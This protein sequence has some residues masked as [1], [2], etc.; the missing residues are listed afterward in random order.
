MRGPWMT[1][2]R[3]RWRGIVTALMAAF[4]LVGLAR[5]GQ[6]AVPKDPTDALPPSIQERVAE[7]RA[8]LARIDAEERVS[9]RLLAPGHLAQWF[10]WNN[11]PNFWRNWANGWRNF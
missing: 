6:A 7:V 4:A 8:A 10:N 11:W 3:R 5:S 2:M 9:G 1:R